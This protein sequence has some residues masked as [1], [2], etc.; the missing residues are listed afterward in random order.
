MKSGIITERLLHFIWQFQY[1][2]FQHLRNEY[3]EEVIILHPGSHNTHQ[4]PDFLN[5][6]IK[7]GETLWFGNVELHINSSDWMQHKH[8][9]DKNY[10]NVILHVVWKHDLDNDALPFPTLEL[11]SL[12]SSVLLKKYEFLMTADKFIACEK[13]ILKVN[14]L[15]LISWKERIVIERLEE[16]T[17]VVLDFVK[18]NKGHWEE[19]L[20]WMLARNFGMKLNVEAFE[21]L[22]KS[23]PIKIMSKNR[24]QPLAIEAMLF[25]QTRLLGNKYLEAYPKMLWKEYNY[26]AKKYHLES[27]HLPIKFL[28]MRPAN[29]PTIRLAQLTTLICKTEHLFSKLL[30]IEELSEVKEMLNVQANDYWHY[31]YSFDLQSE[32]KPKSVG[33]Q[34]VDSIIIN[35]IIPILFAYGQY[36]HQQEHKDKAVVWLMELDAEK[37][38]ITKG[39]EKIGLVNRTAFDSQAYIHLKSKY[40]DVKKCLSC[41]I[42]FQILQVKSK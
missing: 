17:T 1:F 37:N 32:F 26:L 18:R 11:Q 41:N 16:K 6:K 39:F 14:S 25:G 30:N 29:F 13:Q 10:D 31:H 20:W 24:Q 3:G 38:R 2:N 22:A 34:M 33:H 8:S 5:A 23:L 9:L 4:G 19:V 36:H 12:T 35:T 42:G 40:C 28:R 7:M 27:I 15:S 21:E